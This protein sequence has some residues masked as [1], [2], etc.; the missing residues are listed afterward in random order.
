M[1][2]QTAR[3]YRKKV[4]IAS[5]SEVYGKGVRF[6]FH[7][8]DDSVMG[9]TTRSRWSYAA[10]K[11]IDEFLALAYHKEA[12]LPVVIFRLIGHPGAMNYGMALAASVVL[13][14]ATAV[15][16][17]IA[18]AA[19]WTGASCSLI[20]SYPLRSSSSASSLP[21]D[22]TMRPWG[23]LPLSRAMSSPACCA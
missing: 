18:Y 15:V 20:Q 11:A 10:S 9:A 7:E 5:T 3:R 22:F 23:P 16:M 8:D 2:L 4:L 1:V 19:G 6:P 12:G 14:T 17:L 21:A 13:A